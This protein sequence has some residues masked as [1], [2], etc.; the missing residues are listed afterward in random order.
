MYWYVL[1]LAL[2][3]RSE[4]FYGHE[5]HYGDRFKENKHHPGL[6]ASL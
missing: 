6:P 4:D 1:F 2:M 3:F 5:N